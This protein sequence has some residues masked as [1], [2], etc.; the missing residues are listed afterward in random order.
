MLRLCADL[1]GAGHGEYPAEKFEA[2]Q[3]LGLRCDDL[4]TGLEMAARFDGAPH[5]L[6]RY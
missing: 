4:R 5:W 3:S 2:Y 1:C 6:A